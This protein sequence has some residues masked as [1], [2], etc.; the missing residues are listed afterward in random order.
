MPHWLALFAIV[1]A[2]WL[3]LAVVGGWL[4]GRGL[5]VIDR[6]TDDADAAA[7]QRKELPQDLRS[8]A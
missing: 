5:G 1:I 4:I 7:E 3:A 8:A 6:R 2:A